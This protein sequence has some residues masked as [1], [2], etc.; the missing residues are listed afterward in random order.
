[1]RNPDFPDATYGKKRINLNN[2]CYAGTYDFQM[3]MSYAGSSDFEKKRFIFRFAPVKRE[4]GPSFDMANCRD[5]CCF[6]HVL[7][8]EAGGKKKYLTNQR[9][10]CKTLRKFCDHMLH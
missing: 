3:L 9:R 4:R 2:S 5:S 7:D 8:A 1:M 10:V 6:H